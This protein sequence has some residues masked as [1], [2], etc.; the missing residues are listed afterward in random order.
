MHDEPLDKVIQHVLGI[1]R[2]Q[3]DEGLSDHTLLQRF[4][5]CR[6]EMAF[7]WIVQRHGPRVQGLC[8]RLLRNRHDAEDAFQATFLVL[9]RKADALRK[10]ESLGSWL[11]AVA[12]RTAMHIKAS[13]QPTRED[14]DAFP[15]PSAPCPLEQQEAHALLDEELSRL[16]SKYRSALLM[17]LQEGQSVEEAARQLDWTPGQYRG[18]LHRARQLLQKRFRRRGA[19]LTA[20][21]LA[22]APPERALSA[23]LL[24]TTVR[25]ALSFA[26]SQPSLESTSAAALAKT[27]LSSMPT[28]RFK[29]IAAVLLAI[30]LLGVGT[31]ALSAWIAR[32]G[33]TAPPPTAP[34][35]DPL[36][37][38]NHVAALPVRPTDE[39]GDPLP[40]GAIR[41]LGTVRLRHADYVNSVTFSPDGKVLA[42]GSKDGTVRLWEADTGKALALLDAGE[43]TITAVAFAPDGKTLAAGS[44]DQTVR[45][46][47]VASGKQVCQLRGHSDGVWSVAFAP[48]GCVLASTAGRN[49]KTIRLWEVATGR[50]IRQ[51]KGHLDLVGTVAFS[52]DGKTLASGSQDRIVR[53][54]DVASGKEIRQLHGHAGAAFSVA[55]SPDGKTLASGGGD[56]TLRLW[57]VAAGKQLRHQVVGTVWGPVWCVAFSRDGKMLATDGWDNSIRLWD[58]ATGKELREL[59]GHLSTVQCVAFSPDSRTL[60]SGSGN[61]RIEGEGDNTVRLW[62][63][64]SGAELRRPAGHQCALTSVGF[65][66]DRKMLA[67]ASL[68]SSIRLWEAAT[69]K[70]IRPL[71]APSPAPIQTRPTVSP[72]WGMIFS[73]DGK[74]LAA[75]GADKTV[76]LWE[77]AT[78][79]ELR[80]LAGHQ[81]MAWTAAFSPD[82]KVLATGSRD[83]T[84][85]LWEVASGR[86]I[87]CLRGH[88]EWVIH[89]SFSPDGKTV[90]SAC[91]AGTVRWWEAATG[92]ELR[93][94][95]LTTQKGAV[96]AITF[97]PDRKTL[98]WADGTT[99]QLWEAA[100]GKLIHQIG[101]HQSP[102]LLLDFSPDGKTLVTGTGTTIYLW[103]VATG[104]RRLVL[105]EPWNRITSFG[106]SPDGRTLVS[107]QSNLTVLLWDRFGAALADQVP[108]RHFTAAQQD[109]LWAGLGSGDAARAYQAMAALVAAPKEAA[110]LLDERW[111]AALADARKGSRSIAED[112]LRLL[113]TVEIL[114]HLGTMEA[115]KVLRKLTEGANDGLG[116]DAQ[117]ALDRLARRPDLAP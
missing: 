35:D 87:R 43:K 80:C 32:D 8:E 30:G 12:F 20:G 34:F 48:D 101:G 11:H 41:R 6:D 39:H 94:L 69:G 92:K 49:D 38:S 25:G 53:L 85:R 106:F 37:P 68:D 55:F 104:Q 117:A 78:G 95:T 107:A 45:L 88:R 54:W 44:L 116:K 75:C 83:K 19:L 65:S 98:A 2:A 51:L 4:V 111:A 9:A 91:E 27:V 89:V 60:A 5:A 17:Q 59:K 18:V 28:N 61:W 115:Q 103:E 110:P 93:T 109:A 105:G 7:T 50:E 36:V 58:P 67:S 29:V 62:D 100:T 66:P 72:V 64:A 73:A 70:E 1:V 47:E 84:V 82:G 99:V 3:H 13:R 86:E 14:L 76:R 23:S 63:V 97:S 57:D 74:I 90:A 52:P 31:V 112:H 114:E 21:L 46:W 71:V 113:R 79:K 96:S 108:P 10:H 26:M 22:I 33:F 16:P 81:D 15:A 40:A 24:Q 42:S 77:V 56:Q 102:V